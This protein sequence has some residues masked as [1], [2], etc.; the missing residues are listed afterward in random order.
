M[1]ERGLRKYIDEKIFRSRVFVALYMGKFSL[2]YSSL[3]VPTISV[4]S[5]RPA[6]HGPAKPPHYRC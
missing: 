6:R 3:K 2:I 4:S 1:V 5:P